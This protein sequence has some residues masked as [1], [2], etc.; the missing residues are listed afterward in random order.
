M[1][2]LGPPLLTVLR[3]PFAPFPSSRSSVSEEPS[4]SLE[5]SSSSSSLRIVD[6]VLGVLQ[7]NL[8]AGPGLRLGLGLTS[9]KSRDSAAFA[10][11]WSIFG[12]LH[13]AHTL[14]VAGKI[15]ALM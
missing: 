1:E 9:C 5:S 3:T 2:L 10:A 7:S 12:S 14:V 8:R 13:D 4:R 11:L 6:R 15:E